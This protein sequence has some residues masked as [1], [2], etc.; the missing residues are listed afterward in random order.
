MDEIERAAISDEGYDPAVI[1]AL[2]RVS[3]V[4]AELALVQSQ[5]RAPEFVQVNTYV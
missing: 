2:A 4:L 1:A 5:Y 3:V